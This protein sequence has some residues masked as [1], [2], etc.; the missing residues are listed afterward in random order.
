MITTSKLTAQK[1]KMAPA[2]C[3]VRDLCCRPFHSPNLCY[4]ILRPIGDLIIINRRTVFI[5]RTLATREVRLSPSLSFEVT[6]NR[7]DFLLDRLAERR[8][9]P[10][11]L[12][13][14][15]RRV[16]VTEYFTPKLAQIIGRD[17]RFHFGDLIH[18]K[19]V[20][21]WRSLGR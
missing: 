17:I 18:L 10:V 3:V 7:S 2:T 5:T 12:G 11:F 8:A 9:A 6:L 19:S 15:R 1:N 4:R 20:L 14:R 16:Y 21:G 13:H